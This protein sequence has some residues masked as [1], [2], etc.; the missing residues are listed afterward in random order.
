ML[1]FFFVG[2]CII[3][4]EF[5]SKMFFNFELMIFIG[6][7]FLKNFIKEF[8]SRFLNIRII[9]GYGLIEVIVGVSVNDMI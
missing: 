1:I 6:E 7:V 4:K 5:N 9:N 3:E 8:M 2:V